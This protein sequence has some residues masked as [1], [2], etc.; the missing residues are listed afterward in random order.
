M[1]SSVDEAE[2]VTQASQLQ[3]FT[4]EKGK[5]LSR[6][7]TEPNSA[8]LGNFLK[9]RLLPAFLGESS[10]GLRAEERCA[11]ADGWWWPSKTLSGNHWAETAVPRRLWSSANIAKML[12][13]GL[14]QRFAFKH[15]SLNIVDENASNVLWSSFFIAFIHHRRLHTIVHQDPHLKG[16]TPE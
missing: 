3:Q 16:A 5:R 4:R 12:R 7:G 9:V 15:L 13:R 8:C 11:W 14:P 2:P 6:N 1:K 10:P